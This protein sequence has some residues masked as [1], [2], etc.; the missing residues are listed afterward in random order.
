MDALIVRIVQL[1]TS[2]FILLFVINIRQKS[3]DS[4]DICTGNNER[5]FIAAEEVARDRMLYCCR[6]VR[7][8]AQ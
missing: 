6:L 2:I 3:E 5:L 1:I 8:L 4:Q 7:L